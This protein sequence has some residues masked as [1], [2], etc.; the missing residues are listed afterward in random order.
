MP[1]LWPHQERGVN[2]VLEAVAR[3][4]RRICLTCPTGG[5]KTRIA[6]TLI[7]ML[8]SQGKRG[9]LYTNRK[10][11][12][13]QLSGVLNDHGIYHGIRAAGY[14]HEEG[15]DLGADLQVSSIQTE[16]SRVTRK[17]QW[18]LHDA[19]F[20]IVDEAHL[21][22]SSM[23]KALLK[24]H[25]DNGAWQL[26]ITATPL[27]L[28]GMYDELIIAGTNSE[29]RACGALVP[30]IHY[31]CDE[32][33]LRHIGRV[34]V[35]QDLTERQNVRAI[36]VPGV[37]GRVLDHWRRLNP[38]QKPTLLFAPGVAESI[39]FAEQFQEAGIPAAH[40]D[41][42]EVWVNGNLTRSSREARADV[43]RMSENGTIRVLCNRFVLREGIDAPWLAHGILATVFGSLQS[44]LQSGGRLLRAHHSLDSVVVQDHGGNWHRHG[45]LN[46]D[47]EWRL[48]YTDAIVAGLREES[49]RRKDSP[50]PATCPQCKRILVS[51]KCSCGW[52]S[53]TGKKSR[54]VIQADGTL[55]EMVGDIYRPR[56]ETRIPNADEVWRKIYYRASKAGMTFRQAESLFAK[57][58]NWGFPPRDL[59]LMPRK[60]IDW[61]RRVR[62]VP[63]ENLR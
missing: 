63:P 42:Q 11:L 15:A 30:A 10:L 8:L 52:E 7:D 9:V 19:D 13:D 24:G 12:L 26:G 55:R 2:S 14:G 28:A 5:G 36:M 37:F 43:L 32:P 34:V 41:G 48:E 17:G 59:P 46:A 21:Q 3:G 51:L 49:L 53:K 60:D 35:G 62:D 23:A 20:V 22:K 6:C 1:S 44:Y 57:E 29:L 18:G 27:G 58:N 61:F 39:W 50:E 31:G 25:R 38:E 56:R 45:S 16:H 54:P 47:R 33:D 4:V 40:I